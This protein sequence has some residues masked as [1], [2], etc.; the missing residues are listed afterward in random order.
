LHF[1]VL[2]VGLAFQA[3]V[4]A[5]AFKLFALS[6]LSLPLIRWLMLITYPLVEPV[7]LLVVEVMLLLLV[8]VEVALLVVVPLV[9][10]VEVA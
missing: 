4:Q 1:G 6:S 7:L 5:F 2:R 9:E 3:F 10:P 8:V